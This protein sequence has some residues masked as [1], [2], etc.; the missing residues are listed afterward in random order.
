MYDYSPTRIRDVTFLAP[1]VHTSDVAPTVAL[2]DLLERICARPPYFALDNIGLAGRFL[3]AS[4][5]AEAPPFLE[6]AP[7]TSAELGR[8]AAIAGSCHAALSQKDAKRR[9]YL[10]QRA[11]CHYTANSAPYGTPVDFTTEILSLTRRELQ[12]R[13]HALAAGRPLAEF[14]FFYTILTEATFYRLFQ[15]RCLPTCEHTDPY[16]NLLQVPYERGPDW[17]GQKIP[18]LPVEACAGHFESYPALPVAVL[19]GQL[20][21]LAGQLVADVPQ[22]FRVVKGVVEADTLLWARE[23]VC[24]RAD[25]IASSGALQQYR[26]AAFSHAEQVAEMDLWLKLVD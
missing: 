20:S 15:K 7:M 17:A 5:I 16:R 2:P 12:V 18:S 23:P 6:Q 11:T 3:H 14:T 22:P 26:C 4:A 21:Y 8:H 9:F 25:R 24:F 1:A 19:M 10:A 13:A